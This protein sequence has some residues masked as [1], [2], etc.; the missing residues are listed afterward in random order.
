[1]VVQTLN[2]KGWNNETPKENSNQLPESL[3]A[4]EWKFCESL[5]TILTDDEINNLVLCGISINE[6]NIQDFIIYLKQKNIDFYYFGLFCSQDIFA[7]KPLDEKEMN[8]RISF[9]RKL[10]D[11][12]IDENEIYSL[13]SEYNPIYYIPD[14]IKSERWNKFID[15][16][17]NAKNLS[18]EDINYWISKINREVVEENQL[19]NILS[20]DNLLSIYSLSWTKKVDWIKNLV[21]E[22]LRGLWCNET[23]IYF[24]SDYFRYK[25]EI[26]RLIETLKAIR[27][28]KEYNL[29]I[30]IKELLDVYYKNSGTEKANWIK[31]IA[32]KYLKSLELDDTFIKIYLKRFYSNFD[33][34]MERPES[35]HDLV[36]WLQT[37]R[38]FDN[39]QLKTVPEEIFDEDKM[40]D[41]LCKF[42]YIPDGCW[43]LIASS[44]LKEEITDPEIYDGTNLRQEDIKIMKTMINYGNHK[45]FWLNLSPSEFI[46]TFFKLRPLF[47]PDGLKIINS[48]NKTFW[49]EFFDELISEIEKNN[50][51]SKEESALYGYVSNPDL[52]SQ[53]QFDVLKNLIQRHKVNKTIK[54]NR[55]ELNPHRF[56][57]VVLNNGQTLLQVLNSIENY[58]E[59]KINEIN[60]ELKSKPLYD[61]K[62]ISTS[63]W[64]DFNPMG[65]VGYIWETLNRRIFLEKDSHALFRNIYT[66]KMAG[67]LEYMIQAW[68]TT[69]FQIDVETTGNGEKFA[70]LVGYVSTP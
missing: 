45:N 70:Y 51:S 9:L 13:I 48:S 3:T 49:E 53:E 46:D 64:R 17:I 66:A 8:R 25:N 24:I 11:E 50:I 62:I 55:T 28:C 12:N 23:E 54:L 60:E 47:L 38:D 57:E 37:I 1:M 29:Q 34:G 22:F 20:V 44:K 26:S 21:S 6:K 19:D 27:C 40:I 61:S 59:Q 31:T 35:I 42:W 63:I 18:I 10:I 32:Y 33:Y 67:E 30:W 69:I 15:C 14:W 65:K 16:I 2:T 39:N 4:I 7:K 56:D 43:K 52:V 36:L 41:V 68:S 58:D 5:K